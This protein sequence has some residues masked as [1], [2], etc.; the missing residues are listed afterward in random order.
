[1]SARGYGI[2][3]RSSFTY[4][5]WHSGDIALLCASLLLAAAVIAGIA[6]GVLEWQ[7]YPVC[8]PAAR[9]LPYFA[10]LAAYGLLAVLPL[11]YEGKETMTWKRLRSEI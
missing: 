10:V 5:R 2:G 4:F 3:K 7:Y 6:S 8:E 9:Q 1:M 11:I